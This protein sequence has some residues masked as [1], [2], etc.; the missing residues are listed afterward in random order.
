[1]GKRAGDQQRGGE[2][3]QGDPQPQQPGAIGPARRRACGLHEEAG[4]RRRRGV[5]TCDEVEVQV[6]LGVVGGAGGIDVQLQPALG[7]GVKP[8]LGRDEGEVQQLIGV[9]GGARDGH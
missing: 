9:R 7:A 3:R 8:Q 4:R 5:R 1:V 2:H 6:A